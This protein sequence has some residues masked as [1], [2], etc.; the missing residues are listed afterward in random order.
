[1]IRQIITLCTT[2]IFILLLACGCAKT[3]TAQVDRAYYT[4]TDDLDKTVTLNARPQKVIAA[5]GSY[6]ELWLLAGGDLIGVTED[7]MS[8]RGL[9]LPEDVKIIGSVKEPNAEIILAV[10]PDLVLLSTDVEQHVK[11]DETLTNAKI[12]HAYF[13]TDTFDEYLSM[14]KV[15]TD[16][17]STPE[18]YKQYGEE[19][20]SQVD[21]AIQKS[22]A[23]TQADG[24]PSVLLIRSMSTKAKALKSDHPV[25]KM[26]LDLNADN[27]ATLHESLLEDLSMETIIGEDP[28]FI[29]VIRMGDPKKAMETMEKTVMYNPAWNELSAIRN[30]RFF[31]LPKELFQ[32]K[33]NA[34]WGESYEY[35]EAILYENFKPR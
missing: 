5:M 30:D 21:A 17:N 13:K 4:F 35:L 31:V 32:Y 24:K 25:G 28:D 22:A 33:P 2:F 20:K 12:P 26:L 10:N 14:L 16:I 1:M 15:C 7:A 8:E 23:K 18:R 11:L 3:P 27:I 9:Q 19:I 29:F 34:R 6:A